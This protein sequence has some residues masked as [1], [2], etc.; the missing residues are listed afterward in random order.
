MRPSKLKVRIL[1]TAE[2]LGIARFNSLPALWSTQ[3][4]GNNEANA[5]YVPHSRVRQRS[6]EY[7]VGGRKHGVHQTRG[8]WRHRRTR[9]VRKVPCESREEG[10]QVRACAVR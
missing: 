3:Q 10:H 4:G 2:K 5:L 7:G 1:C 6:M 9:D 8:H